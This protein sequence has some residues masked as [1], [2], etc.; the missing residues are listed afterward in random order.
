LDGIE[1]GSIRRNG[2]RTP[3]RRAIGIMQFRNEF[4]PMGVVH[5]REL[6]QCDRL[7]QYSPSPLREAPV[8]C[9]ARRRGN[10]NYSFF[11]LIL[12]LGSGP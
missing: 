4:N 6:T 10:P 3:K 12:F 11:L 2:R 8:G 5:L 9:Q 7:G 1:A